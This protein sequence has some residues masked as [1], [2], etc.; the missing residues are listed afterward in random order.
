MQVLKDYGVTFSL[1]DFGTGFSSL[2]YLKSLPLNQLKIDRSFV[3]HMEKN[4][5]NAKI[6]KS[7]ISLGHDLGLDVIAEGVETEQQLAFLQ[8]HQ[9]RFFQGFLFSRPVPLK[10][11]E[12]YLADSTKI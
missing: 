10:K 3:S 11:F 5:K 7:T 8:K 4:L 1:D 2:N 6:V 12:A 9:C